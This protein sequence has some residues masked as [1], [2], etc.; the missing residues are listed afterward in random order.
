M[1]KRLLHLIGLYNYAHELTAT[2]LQCIATLGG[3]WQSPTQQ[4][5]KDELRKRGYD[6]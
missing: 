4:E 2:Q 5:A 3:D 6:A 1:I